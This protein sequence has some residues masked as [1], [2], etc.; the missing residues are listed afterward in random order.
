MNI[1]RRLGTP[2]F[3]EVMLVVLAVYSIPLLFFGS[4]RN[5]NTFLIWDLFYAVFVASTILAAQSFLL[6][7]INFGRTWLLLLPVV[8]LLFDLTENTLALMDGGKQSKVLVVTDL[9]FIFVGLSILS[10]LALLTID[11]VRRYRNGS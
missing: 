8:Y 6:R 10:V 11:I 2:I 3:L 7:T 1:L 4:V 5:T 9:K